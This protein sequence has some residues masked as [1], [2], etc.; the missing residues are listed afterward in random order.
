MSATRYETFYVASDEDDELGKEDIWLTLNRKE[1]WNCTPVNGSSSCYD[2]IAEPRDN[3]N[4]YVIYM[5]T[6]PCPCA[7]CRLRNYGACTNKDIVGHLTA[8]A[9]NFVDAVDCPDVLATPLTDYPVKV[10]QAFIVMH[11]ERIPAGLT[12]KP[13]LITHITN[14]LAAFVV[15][16]ERADN[17]E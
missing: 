9:I 13:R 3:P 11:Q 10:L 16:G 15:V 8:Q 6:L 12:T 1:K 2:Y 5:R 14:T 7:E 4:E 17:V